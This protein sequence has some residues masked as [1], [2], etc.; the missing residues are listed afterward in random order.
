MF[1][2]YP[3]DFSACMTHGVSGHVAHLCSFA[4]TLTLN[5]QGFVRESVSPCV[6]HAFAQPLAS[7]PG[8][9]HVKIH[10][11]PA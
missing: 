10:P 9:E 8:Q 7:A 5:L 3:T 1:F 11:T 6:G 4:V 2:F